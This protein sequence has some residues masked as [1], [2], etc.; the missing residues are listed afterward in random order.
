MDADPPEFCYSRV[1]PA[2]WGSRK[3]G[4]MRH[5]VIETGCANPEVIRI[6]KSPKGMPV[7]LKIPRRGKLIQTLI[8]FGEK[9][10]ACNSC[11][12]CSIVSIVFKEMNK[13]VTITQDGQEK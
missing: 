7:A 13:M 10:L 3:Q 8:L 12:S 9:S 4:C 6:L 1:G 2:P 5:K 11:L